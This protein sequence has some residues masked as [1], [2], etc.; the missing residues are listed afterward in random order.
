MERLIVVRFWNLEGLTRG[1]SF[2]NL[3]LC[4]YLSP[5]IH[6]FFLRCIQTLYLEV[7]SV[8]LIHVRL[9]L[10]FNFILQF[11]IYV[12]YMQGGSKT[13]TKL[14]EILRNLLGQFRGPGPVATIGAYRYQRWGVTV[15]KS[16]GR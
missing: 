15:P 13:R 12:F 2:W 16:I 3:F 6:V 10:S 9:G 11:S 4:D 1:P 8:F 14:D 7:F 5:L